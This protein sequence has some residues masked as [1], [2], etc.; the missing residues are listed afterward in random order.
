MSEAYEAVWFKGGKEVEWVD[1][2]IT[3]EIDAPNPK[4]ITVYNGAYYYRPGD[5]VIPEDVDDFVVR[6]KQ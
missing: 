3:V 1:P 4:A 5:G 2:V 6:K